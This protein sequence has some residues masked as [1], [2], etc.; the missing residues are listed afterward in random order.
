MSE[1]YPVRAKTANLGGI[2]NLRRL[3][4]CF[5]VL[6]FAGCAAVQP[7][8]N[9]DRKNISSVTISP[10]VTKPAAMFYLGPGGVT[11]LMFGAIGG[12][13]SAGSIEESRKSFQQYVDRNGISVEKIV[14]EEVSSA[15]R[16]SGK[17][18]LAAAPQPGGA[19]LVVSIVQYGFSIPHGFSSELVPI[20]GVRCEMKDAAGKLLWSAQEHTRPLGNPVESSKPDAIR[21]DPKAMEGS[22][23]AAAKHI[24]AAIVAGY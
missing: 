21:N 18:P 2:V 6:L 1:S 13:L 17:F 20:L 12:A 15:L 16:Q 4:T 5:L 8:S 22:W 7:I 19:V 9:A 23:R 10:E 14:Y 3:A 24:A 11:G